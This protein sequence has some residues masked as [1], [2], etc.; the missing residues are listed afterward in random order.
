MKCRRLKGWVEKETRPLCSGPAGRWEGRGGLQRKGGT[1]PEQPVGFFF[2]KQMLQGFQ[3]IHDVIRYTMWYKFRRPSTGL[4]SRRR[5]VSVH[6]SGRFLCARLTEVCLDHPSQILHRFAPHH[7]P[8]P[9][10]NSNVG[11]ISNLNTFWSSSHFLECLWKWLWAEF[12]GGFQAR[13]CHV[14]NLYEPRDWPRDSLFSSRGE[15]LLPSV[16]EFQS[17]ISL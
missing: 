1:G 11:F 16:Q 17:E 7:L 15:T 6:S 13:A 8:R 12:P 4:G 5:R 2:G 9:R 14:G 10:A 3:V